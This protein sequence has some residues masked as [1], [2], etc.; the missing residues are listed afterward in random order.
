MEEFV[1]GYVAVIGRPNVGKST[2]VNELLNFPLS[3]VTRKPQTTRHRL[4]GIL[5]EGNY[6]V[7]FQDTPGILV[8]RYALQ[9]LMV[10]SAWAVI[11]DADLVLLMTEPREDDFNGEAHILSGLK[12]AGRKVVLAV[13]KIDLVEKSSLLPLI[14]FYDRLFAFVEIVPISALKSDG[15]DDLKKIIISNLPRRPP[16]YPPDQL[17]DRPQRFFAGE[18]IRQKV[19]EQFGEEIPYSVAVVIDEY[20]ERKDSK[21][22]IRATLVCERESQKPILIGRA[23][24]AIKRLGRR[25]RKELERFLGKSVFIDL[26]VEVRKNWRKEERTIKRL[27]QV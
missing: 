25:A 1:C 13:N 4:L 20:K 19:F 9:K 22:Y 24:E 3:I 12:R 17:T 14:G 5:S 7:I 16:F 21:D 6:Q 8:P 18:I 23:G 10:E 15:L 11:E 2:L 27:G 26:K